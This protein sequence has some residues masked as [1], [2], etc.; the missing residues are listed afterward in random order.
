MDEIN[1]SRT[2]ILLVDDDP[3]VL[4]TLAKGLTEIGYCVETAENGQKALDHY[5]KGR[6][7]LVI[8]DYRMPDMTGVEVA[9]IMLQESY[10]PILILSAN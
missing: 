4:N 7:D 5:R 2:R 1:R 9:R 10:R 6:P 3:I 8:L